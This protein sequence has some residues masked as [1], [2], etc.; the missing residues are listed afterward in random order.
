MS[1]PEVWLRGPMPGVPPL[2]M[3]AAHA[4]AGAGEDVARAAAG[5]TVEQLWARPA[6]VASVGFHLRHIPGV[7]DRL[8]TY[9]RGE[10]LTDAQLAYLRAEPEPGNPAPD[11][12]ELLRGVEEGIALALAQIAA[13][14]E[15]DLLLPRGVGRLQL[16]STVMGLIFHAAEHAQRHTGQVVTLSRIV[17]GGAS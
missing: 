3:P 17:R 15:E 4:L 6:G 13:T 7:L 8:L 14:R 12:D 2:L 9:A 11:A 16:P 5:L 10:S 1:Q